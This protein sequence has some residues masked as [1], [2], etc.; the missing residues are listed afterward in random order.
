MSRLISYF[1]RGSCLPQGEVGGAWVE[2]WRCHHSRLQS[3]AT[4]TGVV[5]Y[6]R[7]QETQYLEKGDAHYLLT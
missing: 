5:V 3:A 2:S 6:N 7:L 4:A 1:L